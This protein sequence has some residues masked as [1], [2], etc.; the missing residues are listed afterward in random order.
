MLHLAREIK[1]VYVM[2]NWHLSKNAHWGHVLF[3]S[4]SLTKCWFSIRSWAQ[5]GLTLNVS[6]I[7]VNFNCYIADVFPLQR[8][9]VNGQMTSNNETV[10]HQMPWAGNIA[11]TVKS[12]GKQFA[13]TAKCWPLLHVITG[14]LMSLQSRRVFQNL[15]KHWDYWETKFTVPLGT[16]H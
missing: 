10:S 1:N 7:N 5:V 4:L 6:K 15:G 12:D 8:A 3:W 16:T 2:T 13:V 14:G 11:K 9:L